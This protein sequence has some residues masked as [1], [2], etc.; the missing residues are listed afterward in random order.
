MSIERV[1]SFAIKQ[2][3]KAKQRKQQKQI[4]KQKIATQIA[5]NVVYPIM[6][7]GQNTS[8]Q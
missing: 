8:P 2:E 7:S 3:N 1:T 6:T 5:G 4:W